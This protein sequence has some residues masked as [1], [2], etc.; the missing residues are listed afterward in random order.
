MGWSPTQQTKYLTVVYVL[1][2][3]SL[4]QLLTYLSHP[5]ILSIEYSSI[6]QAVFVKFFLKVSK[7]YGQVEYSWNR[8]ICYKAPSQLQMPCFIKSMKLD[9]SEER[10]NF[11]RL[12]LTLISLTKQHPL[13]PL[14]CWTR[15]HCDIHGPW[16]R[17]PMS[18]LNDWGYPLHG[19]HTVQLAIPNIL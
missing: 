6:W 15:M 2:D 4:K 11:N 10:E 7:Y 17:E 16:A 1:V 5:Q 19:A 13:Q 8:K 14:C 18:W 12:I 9:H 3:R